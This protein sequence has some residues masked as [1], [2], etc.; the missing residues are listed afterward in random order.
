ME[1]MPKEI[2]F[3]VEESPE[4]GYETQALGYSI[5]PMERLL[6]K[7][8]RILKMRYAAILKKWINRF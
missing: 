2:I 4:G 6:M 5:S 7:S 8:K 3:L 1:E